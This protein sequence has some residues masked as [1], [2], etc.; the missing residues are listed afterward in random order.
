MSVPGAVAA[1][2]EPGG[3]VDPLACGPAGVVIQRHGRRDTTVRHS[4]SRSQARSDID[5]ALERRGK[6]SDIN[7]AD[8][9]AI[10]RTAELMGC[11]TA[12]AHILDDAHRRSLIHAAPEPSPRSGPRPKNTA[13]TSPLLKLHVGGAQEADADDLFWGDVRRMVGRHD[14]RSLSLPGAM[15]LD[16][17]R[18][19]L[20]ETA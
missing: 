1:A 7:A 4:I 14:E 13:P 3:F 5:T 12:V 16:A 20:P 19:L 18:M 9:A 11:H 2:L 10:V 6:M 17:I 8:R 15:T